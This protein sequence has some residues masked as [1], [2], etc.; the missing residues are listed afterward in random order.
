MKD[1]STSQAP[2]STS[3]L[4]EIQ[5][6]KM[7][8]SIKDATSSQAPQ[9]SSMTQYVQNYYSSH[10]FSLLCLS[11]LTICYFFFF[12][13]D[14]Q[15]SFISP[16]MSI[17]YLMFSSIRMHQQIQV[18][19]MRSGKYATSSQAPQA[20]SMIHSM[21]KTTILTILF[22]TLIVKFNHLLLYPFFS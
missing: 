18:E 11:S 16:D 21:F 2:Q 5:V 19:K 17:I 4:Q 22:L 7:R 10:F 20:S 8:S 12:L 14:V 15:V 9:A 13:G 1:A 3:M 6:K